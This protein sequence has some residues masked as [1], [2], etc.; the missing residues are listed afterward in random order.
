MRKVV[1]ILYFIILFMVIFEL[2]LFGNE[3]KI[4]AFWE[5]TYGGSGEDRAM[6][7]QQTSDGGYIVAGYTESFGA[8][9]VDVYI[10]KL[11]ANGNK[12]WEKTYG[13]SNDDGATSIQ[14]TKDGGYIVAGVTESFGAGGVDV[15]II[16]LDANGSKVWEKTYGG[17]NDDWVWSIQ[18][19]KDGG[20]IVA[21]YTGPFGTGNLNLYIINL[22][23]NGNMIWGKTY[24][25]EDIAGA[26]SAQQTND[27]GYIA[28]GVTGSFGTGDLNLY[29]I[30]LDAN[31]NKVWEKTYGGSNDDWVWSIQQTKD[32][33][34]IVAGWT[35]SFGEGGEDVYIIKLDA[36]GNKLW[37]RT[38]GGTHQD[39]AY[40]IQQ[41]KDGGYIVAGYTESFGAGGSD[42]YVIKL[43]EFGSLVYSISQ[44]NEWLEE[45]GDKYG[46]P[47][48]ILKAIAWQES[49]WRHYDNSGKIIQSSQGYYGIMQVPNPNSGPRENIFEGARIL[50]EEKWNLSMQGCDSYPN[51]I[52][53][54]DVR[55]DI[56]E[57]WFYA[58]VMYGH[59]KESDRFAYVKTIYSIIENPENYHDYI[60][61]K[62]KS[63]SKEILQYFYPRVKITAPFGMKIKD[64]DGVEKTFPNTYDPKHIFGFTL[65][66]LVNNGGIIHDK[67]GNDITQDLFLEEVEEIQEEESNYEPEAQEIP[68]CLLTYNFSEEDREVLM[69]G[70]LTFELETGRTYEYF[71]SEDDPDICS[72]HWPRTSNSGV[73]IGAGYDLGQRDKGEIIRNLTNAGVG[74]EQAKK[75]AEAASKRG[76]EARY[77]CEENK[78]KEW[79]KIGKEQVIKLFAI[80]LKNVIEDAKKGVNNAKTW[81]IK[82]DTGE[83][84]TYYPQRKFENLPLIVQ[85][86]VVSIAYNIGE[87][88]FISQNW[89]GIF[90]MDSWKEAAEY[91]RGDIKGEICDENG[92][93]QYDKEGKVIRA[94]TI[95]KRWR[96]TV[97]KRADRIV[98]ELEKA[99][100]Y[101]E[102]IKKEEV[103]GSLK[104]QLLYTLGEGERIFNYRCKFLSNKE[105][106]VEIEKDKR[107]FT[108]VNGK[109]VIPNVNLIFSPDGKRYAY[110]GWE[111]NHSY[112]VV[113]G[114]KGPLFDYIDIGSFKFSPDSKRF[115]YIAS[116]GGEREL[117][118]YGGG[119]WT[120]VVDKFAIDKTIL[121]FNYI[122][123]FAFSPDSKTYAYIA[124]NGGVWYLDRTIY[125][126]A[127]YYEGGKWFV[128]I[129]R[130]GKEN[131]WNI[132][133]DFAENLIFDTEGRRYGFIGGE[134]VRDVNSGK[135]YN[136]Y[137]IVTGDA[138]NIEKPP[139]EYPLVEN[140]FTKNI[141]SLAPGISGPNIR[142][143]VLLILSPDL[144][145]YAYV[146]NVKGEN[147]LIIDGG[148]F[149]LYK[150]FNWNSLTFSPDGTK[151]A[152]IAKEGSKYFVVV[153]G[154]KG[155]EYD[156]VRNLTFSSDSKKVAYIASAGGKQFVVL[157]GQK[158]Y[159]YEHVL[160]LK[161]FDKEKTFLAIAERD[162]KIYLLEF[163]G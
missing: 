146:A 46:I 147:F 114:K 130:D 128:I 73:T 38:Y 81:G 20:Y 127:P 14:Q 61:G 152:Y 29:V 7:I 129:N 106:F 136:R 122:S 51:Y 115:G 135:Y 118:D 134:N 102:S 148:K 31:G 132:D 131:Y 91:I 93:P 78:N 92:N 66:D 39:E 76:E 41:T 137:Y 100:S 24:S 11:D 161:Y 158:G 83:I 17:S 13:G 4:Q 3:A 89:G 108:L 150:G 16:K 111:N 116:I 97:K 70:D 6:S 140:I 22:D 68:E 65:K 8:G 88:S 138:L 26:F 12:V 145:S 82:F 125:M 58:I 90:Q 104:E 105:W 103:I 79:A 109:V 87:A 149:P 96:E 117:G 10:I 151:V 86:I 153:N 55:K 37:E 27:G 43:D 71:C 1:Y 48:I 49:N 84:K 47:P 63:V 141:F 25:G 50:G 124:S 56:L 160:D 99:Q 119:V 28:A 33:G 142:R 156:E 36:N 133:C 98:E 2:T 35:E 121:G 77:F 69:Y 163:G 85:K 157:D 107:Y 45:A 101:D 44:I 75:L 95:L 19:T 120:V 23:T 113:D 18:Q 53:E 34:Y 15:Y 94:E 64:V 52:E 154:K 139:L 42:L 112:V 59:L 57:N 80:S 144:W 62:D 159:E 72:I 21:G 60:S 162:G 123:E 74:E 5:K 30:K 110:V 155:K 40:S 143:N 126:D 54:Y 67:D 32:G 9:G